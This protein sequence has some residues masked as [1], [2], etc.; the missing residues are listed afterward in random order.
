MKI[1]DRYDRNLVEALNWGVRKGIVLGAFQGYMW[2]IIFLCYALAFW[3]GS[4]LVIETNE[5]S[6]GGLVQVCK[7]TATSD[8]L[9]NFGIS[10]T[11]A[12]VS[13]FYAVCLQVFFAVLI[14]AINLG[15]ASPC[16]QAFASGRAAAQIIF[17][18]IERVKS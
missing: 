18:T 1:L 9:F 11:V 5:L 7:F 13:P 3:Y 6:A 10:E 14:A 12:V 2:A 8:T 16:L 4:Q 15:A 17:S